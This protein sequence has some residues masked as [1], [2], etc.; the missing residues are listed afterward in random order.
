MGSKTLTVLGAKGAGKK[1]LIGSLIYKCGMGLEQLAQLESSTNGEYADIVSFFEE[2]GI[3]KS[4]Y[5]PSANIVVE[6]STMPDIACWVV[7]ATD[8]DRG[9]A[10]SSELTSLISAGLLKP[11]DKLLILINKMYRRLILNGTYIVPISALRGGNV[12]EM[13]HHLPWPKGT[14]SLDHPGPEIVT[15]RTVMQVLG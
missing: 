6:Q 1:T 14:H 9:R 11:K 10:S 2:N 12:L 7:D 5:A 13:P 8:S 3:A 15:E 4:F